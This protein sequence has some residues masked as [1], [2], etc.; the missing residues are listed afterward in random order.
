[1]AVYFLLSSHHKMAV[2]FVIYTLSDPLFMSVVQMAWQSE[3]R[4]VVCPPLAGAGL[5][6]VCV[7]KSLHGRA[8][9]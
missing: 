8:F 7:T 6:C 1:M 2:Y 4:P 9:V 3:D 5:T